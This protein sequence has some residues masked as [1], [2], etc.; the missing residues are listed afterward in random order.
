MIGPMTAPTALRPP[1]AH[2][3]VTALMAP[4]LGFLVARLL[5]RLVGGMPSWLAY[6]VCALLAVVV[7]YRA[8]TTR[9]ELRG[10]TVAVVNTLLT[11]RVPLAEVT[12]VN[13]RG[14]IEVTAASSPRATHLPAEALHQ[15][16]WAFGHGAEVYTLNREQVRGWRRRATDADAAA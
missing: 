10:D 15:P 5:L 8:W 7:A 1:A 2:R 3:I 12:R 6:G 14:R 11:T 16:W 9:I 4:V 13:D